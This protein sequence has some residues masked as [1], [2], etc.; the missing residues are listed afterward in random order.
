MCGGLGEAG[1]A[2]PA[3]DGMRVRSGQAQERRKGGW[4]AGGAG[5]QSLGQ[6]QRPRKEAF[7]EKTTSQVSDM[8]T[9]Q[10]PHSPITSSSSRGQDRVR[11]A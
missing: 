11:P 5:G 2:R 4:G 3:V 8:D 9:T 7:G 1:R 6:H 10:D